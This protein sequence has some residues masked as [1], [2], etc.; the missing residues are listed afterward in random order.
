ME[1]LSPLGKVIH[2]VSNSIG[3]QSES[4]IAHYLGLKNIESSTGRLVGEL[5][6]PYAEIKSTKT[7]FK[8]GDILYGKLRPN[9]NK[10]H[11]AKQDGICSTDIL[12]LRPNSKE[13]GIFYSRYFL[14]KSF[15]DAV[16]NTVSGQQLPRTSWNRMQVINIPVMKPQ[17]L[18]AVTAKIE[19]L[20]KQ[21]AD[22]Q[23]VIDAAPARKEEVMKKY[24]S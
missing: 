4:G 18:A 19:A 17:D 9:F 14:S 16:V 10:A 24:L 13:E 5:Y 20:E 15:N 12:V 8:S 23:A 11:L 2:K 1:T 3:P 7:A 21:I 6:T 22:T